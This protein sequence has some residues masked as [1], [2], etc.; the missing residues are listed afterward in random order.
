MLF[1]S[2]LSPAGRPVRHNISTAGS[3]KQMQTALVGNCPLGEHINAFIFLLFLVPPLIEP[4]RERESFHRLRSRGSNLVVNL[5][6]LNLYF[7][8]KGNKQARTLTGGHHAVRRGQLVRAPALD[9]AGGR[10]EK[11]PPAL[12]QLAQA[13]HGAHAAVEAGPLV[14]FPFADHVAKVRPGRPLHCKRRKKKN[15]SD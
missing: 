11:V 4:L 6:G 5:P 13:A 15:D 7:G 12:D 8:N 10:S 3:H 9:V 2:Q 1:S 14:D